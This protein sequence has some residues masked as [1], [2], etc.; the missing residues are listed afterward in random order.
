VLLGALFSLD[1]QKREK[2]RRK[3]A[4]RCFPS[5]GGMATVVKTKPSQ[6]FSQLFFFFSDLLP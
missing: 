2:A 3:T 1:N 4:P 5:F 6:A